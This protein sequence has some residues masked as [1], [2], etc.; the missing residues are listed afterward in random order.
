M[1]PSENEP[2]TFRLIA[3]C[4]NQLDHRV[5]HHASTMLSLH[6]KTLQLYFQIL[7]KIESST[8]IAFVKAVVAISNGAADKERSV[9]P[10]EDRTRTYACKVYRARMYKPKRHRARI[11]VRKFSK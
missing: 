11:Y 7:K 8:V 5:P 10:G 3:Q 9:I 1:T 6:P 2:A 4:L